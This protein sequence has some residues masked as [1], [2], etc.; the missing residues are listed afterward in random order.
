M[1]FKPNCTEKA[2]FKLINLLSILFF[3]QSSL[4]IILGFATLA[5]NDGS[6]EQFISIV[7]YIAVGGVLGIIGEQ[8]RSI[9]N[10]MIDNSWRKQ[11]C[12]VTLA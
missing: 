3:V 6:R 12:M 5:L 4:L 11:Y 10:D 8:L 1:K 7:S 2:L 9:K